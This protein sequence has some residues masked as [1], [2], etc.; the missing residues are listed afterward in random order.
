MNSEK[1][2]S[3]M[4]F[5]KVRPSSDGIVAFDC[6]ADRIVEAALK[7][8]REFECQ[9]LTDLAA[10]DMGSDLAKCRFGVVY[11]L[12]SH[13]KKKYVRLV[14]MCE[15]AESPHINSLTGVYK[16]ADW[17]EREA[18]DLMGIVFDGH[19]RLARI[20]MW[21][22]YPWHPLR[23]DFPLAGKEAPLPDTFAGNEDA[24]RVVP[25]PESG[26][27]FHSPS[28]GTKF[29]CGREPRSMQVQTGESDNI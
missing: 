10:V 2:L 6:P 1:I 12:F 7:L 22:S 18:Y 20:L 5:L 11:H 25:A 3:E 21:D 17:L 29:S 24:T 14:C 23:K 26:G 28:S 15:S 9:S 8:K 19:P 16:G 27:P 13:T 4:D